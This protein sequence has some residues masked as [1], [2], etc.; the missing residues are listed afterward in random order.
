MV[1]GLL[2]L[3]LALSAVGG[4]AS[5]L[6]EPV[7]VRAADGGH[8]GFLSF[9][10]TRRQMPSSQRLRRRR[11][12]SATLYNLTNTAYVIERECEPPPPRKRI[13]AV[14]AVKS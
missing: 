4:L 7:V 10:V 3:S 6:P 11:D 8:A 2:I 12:D 14:G 1:S 5:A 13:G 9:P